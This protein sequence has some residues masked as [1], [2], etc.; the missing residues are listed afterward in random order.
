MPSSASEQRVEVAR[1]ARLRWLA[2]LVLI[3]AARISRLSL[4]KQSLVASRYR[5][6]SLGCAQ[7]TLHRL[8]DA[9]FTVVRLVE[10]QLCPAM[11]KCQAATLQLVF[12][13]PQWPFGRVIFEQYR[14]HDTPTGPSMSESRFYRF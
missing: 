11:Q 13:H 2:A 8:R 6:S 5:V 9:Y 10:A 4:T 7:T 12:L 1:A 3:V 14:L